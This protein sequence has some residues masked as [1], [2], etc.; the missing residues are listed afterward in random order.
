[1]VLGTLIIVRAFNRLL[2]LL[3]K[4][5]FLL[6]HHVFHVAEQPAQTVVSRLKKS[7][8]KCQQQSDDCLVRIFTSSKTHWYCKRSFIIRGRLVQGPTHL[9]LEGLGTYKSAMLETI[10]MMR[11]HDDWQSSTT[12]LV[13]V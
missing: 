2:I 8:Y 11:S 13:H 4:A 10:V 5:I 6:T 12:L 3:E 1:M 9:V 7:D